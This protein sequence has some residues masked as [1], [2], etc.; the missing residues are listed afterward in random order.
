MDGGGGGDAEFKTARP[1]GPDPSSK[2]ERGLGD[3]RC[4]VKGEG[5]DLGDFSGLGVG[6]ED[7]AVGA[8]GGPG[9]AAGAG[10]R[11]RGEKLRR[12]EGAVGEKAAG[13]EAG[14]VGLGFH[15]QP[16]DDGGAIGQDDGFQ[17]A[18]GSAK[19]DLN[20]GGEGR[21]GIDGGAGEDAGDAFGGGEPRN[22]EDGV[23][24]VGGGAVDGTSG[25]FPTVIAE[26]GGLGP[27]SGGEIESGVEVV[28]DL[29]RRVAAV[30]DEDAVAGEDGDGVLAAGANVGVDGPIAQR[31]AGG[32]EEA[33]EEFHGRRVVS[34]RVFGGTGGVGIAFGVG[35]GVGG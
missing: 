8:E 30:A 3:E 10:L 16:E 22:G 6:D 32:R 11:S 21:A 25:D 1:G 12:G 35:G 26:R 33:G 27:R 20:R 2:R 19:V 5:A 31:C 13:I 14:G 29:G 18:D 17:A 7:G 15:F 28:T 9:E 34:I 23:E 4:G 24:G